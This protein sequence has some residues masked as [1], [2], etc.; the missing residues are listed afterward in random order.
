[1]FIFKDAEKYPNVYDEAATIR[2]ILE[3]RDSAKEEEEEEE[4]SDASDPDPRY[5]PPLYNRGT[6][7]W[8]KALELAGIQLT[9]DEQKIFSTS[10]SLLAV[11]YTVTTLRVT[12]TTET[13]LEIEYSDAA[14][15][16][17]IKAFR[18]LQYAVN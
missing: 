15:S 14:K 6:T 13:I 1:M 7:E 10:T 5:S 18:I 8:E 9:A 11:E 16:L 2:G 3:E 17:D 12:V 4:G